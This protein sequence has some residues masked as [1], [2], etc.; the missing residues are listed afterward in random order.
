[1]ECSEYSYY[2]IISVLDRRCFFLGLPLLVGDIRFLD[3][4]SK[5][6]GRGSAFMGLGYFVVG[7]LPPSKWIEH[8]YV[9]FLTFFVVNPFLPHAI[10]HL[11][12]FNV[13]SFSR[14][15][16]HSAMFFL[17]IVQVSEKESCKYQEEM[18]QVFVCLFHMSPNNNVNYSSSTLMLQIYWY[19]CLCRYR[20]IRYFHR[21]MEVYRP[22]GPPTKLLMIYCVFV[23]INK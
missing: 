13:F 22:R 11:W 17:W 15:F 1:M 5:F 19:F 4:T 21:H 3:F 18:L 23:I 20:R 2:Y 14:F 8:I 6:D 16:S 9:S 7:P 12:H 10:T